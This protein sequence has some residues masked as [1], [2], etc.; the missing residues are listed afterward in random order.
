[1]EPTAFVLGAQHKQWGREN[2]PMSHNWKKGCG[3]LNLNQLVGNWN[4]KHHLTNL[5]KFHHNSS[6]NTQVKAF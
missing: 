6:T 2:K 3:P 5:S 1:M 4:V